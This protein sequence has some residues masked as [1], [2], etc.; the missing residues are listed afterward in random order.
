MAEEHENQDEEL[1]LT[2][3]VEGEEQEEQGEN[4][5]SAAEA[6]E[7]DEFAIEI[8]GD[9]PEAETP[10]IK[11]LR[12][13]VRA[14]QKELAEHRKVNA[15][16]VEVGKE[17]DLWDD[18]EGDPEK[19]KKELLAFEERKRK[20]AEQDRDEQQTVE[21]KNQEF[22]R[23]YVTYRAKAAA[24]PVKDFDD[25]EKA[26]TSSLPELLQS[27]IVAY[28]EDPA[29]VVYAL[30]KHPAKLA[31]LSQ[32]PDPVK[33]VLAMRDLERS[34]KVVNKRKPPAPEAE[35]IQSGSAQNAQSGDKLAEKLLAE[36]QRTGDMTKY[37]AHMKAK[38]AA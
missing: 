1:L 31:A 36:A 35:T 27:A 18:C 32:E 7:G 14:A 25:A 17:P 34:L 10:L 11:Q 2:E 6:P 29:K 19:Y 28:A 33:F 24:L 15:P 26:V 20:R 38:R 30:A 5:G 13:E 3:E 23:R 4:T 9:E 22:Q 12:A 8:D 37:R 16:K 21:V